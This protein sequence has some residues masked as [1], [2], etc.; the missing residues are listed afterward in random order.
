M[1]GRGFC[2]SR[3]LFFG[4]KLMCTFPDKLPREN[5]V[6]VSNRSFTRKYASFVF[7]QNSLIIDKVS[8]H[9]S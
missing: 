7:Y 4:T 9:P 3:D 6:L 1:I 8:L 2:V 5:R